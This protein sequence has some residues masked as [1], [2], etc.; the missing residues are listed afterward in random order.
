[1][2][3]TP[4]TALSGVHIKVHPTRFTLGQVQISGVAIEKQADAIGKTKDLF[5][6]MLWAKQRT[7]SSTCYGQ[8]KGPVQ[9]HAMGKT[10]DLFRPG[11]HRAHPPFCSS[12][13]PARLLHS[14]VRM[15]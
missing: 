3:W 13:S 12:L 7:C 5:R 10:K 8:D 14:Y 15:P 6:Y 4:F 9:V 1:M 11:L 2:A